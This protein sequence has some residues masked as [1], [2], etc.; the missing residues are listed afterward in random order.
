MDI[1]EFYGDRFVALNF[2]HNFGEIVP[3]LFRIPNIAAFGLEFILL[4]N[5]AYTQF[6]DSALF[7]EGN[8]YLRP[9][10]TQGTPDKMY[11]EVGLGINRLLLFFRFDIM[12]RF[13]QV[14]SPRIQI[15]IGGASFR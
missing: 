2:E 13:S 1:K 8:D 15:N 14:D 6:S 10:T 7:N 9:M 12:A 3:G 5:A 4:A 11:Y